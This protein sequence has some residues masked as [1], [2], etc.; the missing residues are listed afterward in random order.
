LGGGWE[1]TLIG[2]TADR[3]QNLFR[4]TAGNLTELA[5]GKK[6]GFGRELTR[7]IGQNTPGGTLPYVRLAYERV[8][9]DQLQLLLDPE[10]HAAWRR[11]AINRRRDYGN[12]M[13]WPRGEL[14]PQRAPDMGAALGRR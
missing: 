14:G 11:Q 5:Q 7:F 1:R 8:L 4:L 9:L 13:W 3:A 6:T 10:A 12:E 2:P